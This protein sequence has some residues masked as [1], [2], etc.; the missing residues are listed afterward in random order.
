MQ[1][2]SAYS[3][4]RHAICRIAQRG[5]S[6]EAMSVLLDHGDAYN[7]GQGC[8]YVQLSKAALRRLSA[9]G[10]PERVLRNLARLQAVVSGEGEVV[11]C[12]YASDS[13]MGISRRRPSCKYN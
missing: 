3:F 5:I 10:A 1:M 8:S 7:A 12:Y 13:R 4:S 11:T 2:Q 6:A 9:E